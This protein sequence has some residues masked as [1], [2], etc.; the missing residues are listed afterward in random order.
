M[1]DLNYTAQEAGAK[2][3]FTG[4]PMTKHVKRPRQKT[5]IATLKPTMYDRKI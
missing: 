4:Q 1:D 5:N 3:V 2:V